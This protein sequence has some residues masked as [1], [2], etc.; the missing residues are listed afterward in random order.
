MVQMGTI[1]K[2]TNPSGQMVYRAQI[3]VKKSG[4]PDFSESRTFSKKSLAT[5]WI[6]KREAEIEQN[7]NILF[8]EKKRLYPTLKDAV[9]K[10][11][12]ESEK[13]GRSK[14]MGLLFLSSFEIG[15]LRIDRI[16]RVDYAEHIMLRRR[17]IPEEG[18]APIVASTALQEL[19]Y[20]RTVL[21]HAFYVWDMP[22]SW[23]ELDFAVEGLG[24]SGMVA[25]S[26]KRD[27]LPTSDE[28]QQLTNYFY[29]QWHNW[30]HVNLIPMHLIMWLAIYTT[31]RQDEICRMLLDDY[32]PDTAEWLIRDVKHPK[33]S[34]GNHKWFDVRPNA[35]PVIDALMQPDMQKRMAKCKGIKNSLVPLD[36]KSISSG[37]TRACNVLGIED[38]RFH[39]LRHEG[40]TR[41]AEDGAT[42]PQIQQVTLHNSWNSLQRYV[43]LR[44]RL[45]RLDFTDAIEKAKQEFEQK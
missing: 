26:K 38:L 39:D 45:E 21:K 28:L 7:P 31:R 11:L 40:A 37:F 24:K 20:I 5:E 18:I 33:G 25:K 16:K 34:K 8:G 22:V 14:R 42:I 9:K 23:Q 3:R 36:A 4:Y 44:K 41:L 30:R 15:K 17:G 2:R 32:R 27:R 29:R 43:N 6:K 10:Y 35:L 12:E 13:M 19:Q 1:T